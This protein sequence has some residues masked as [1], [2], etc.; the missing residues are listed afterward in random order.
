MA[1]R[2]HLALRFRELFLKRDDEGAGGGQIVDSGQ[3]ARLIHSL[4]H[5]IGPRPPLTGDAMISAA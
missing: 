3:R 1:Q 4:H 2:G 5:T